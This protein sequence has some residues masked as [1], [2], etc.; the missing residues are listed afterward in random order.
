MIQIVLHRG[1]L[2]VI[3]CSYVGQWKREDTIL[4]LPRISFRLFIG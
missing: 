1:L 2:W 3:E 4:K